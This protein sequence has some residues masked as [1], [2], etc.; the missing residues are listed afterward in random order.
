MPDEL[1]E[2]EALMTAWL[3]LL[4]AIGAVAGI[5]LV[6]GLL[7]AAVA[8]L[9]GFWMLGAAVPAGVSVVTLAATAAPF[10]GVPWSL[11]PVA[12]MSIAVLAVVLVLRRWLW[13]DVVLPQPRALGRAATITLI[14]APIA[15]AV[16][17]AAVI[18][19]PD[20]ISQTFDNI[21]HLNGIRF[22]LDTANASPFHLG[23]MT[24]SHTGGVPFYPS[25]WHAIG[26]LI[27]QVS[28]VSIPVASNA[29][30]FFF[31]ALW[32][33]SAL[34]LAS[35]L[36]RV[37][38]PMIVAAAATAIAVPSFPLL[39]VD[40]GVLYPY[41]LSFSM[42]GTA[43][44][45]AYLAIMGT[46]RERWAFAVISLGTL[47]GI[48]ISHPGGFMAFLLLATV[49]GAIRYVTFLRAPGPRGL[50]RWSL[51]GAAVYVVV[52]V[53]IWS[54]ARPPAEARN[55]TVEQSLGQAIGE[56]ATTSLLHGALNIA[57]MVLVTVGVVIAARRRST[58]DIVALTLLL[59]TGALFIIVSAL[60][61]WVLRDMATGP[62]YN[63]APRLAALLP[64]AWVP[65]VGIGGSAIWAWLTRRASIVGSPRLA[66]ALVAAVVALGLVVLPQLAV[67]R[68]AVA[69]AHESYAL[70][71][72]SLL[73][74]T[75]EKALLERLADHV[76]ADAV[77][78]GSAWTGTALA[79]AFS[80]RQV[81]LP[82]TLTDITPEMQTILD[83][84]DSAAADEPACRAADDLGVSFVLDFGHL[85]VHEGEHI[86]AGLDRLA[87]SD[88][89][90]LIDSEGEA[91]LYA[92]TGCGV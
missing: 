21:F 29:L 20:A 10:V 17:L 59:V 46:G 58:A 85:E 13:R 41:M 66:R 61:F 30:M 28:G 6:P 1:T 51:V 26:A 48:A 39:L 38:T 14:A 22:A 87:K 60:P 9:R 81:L 34:L 75:D 57:V 24:S 91:R 74:S 18:G 56:V 42:L 35:A 83:G 67:M 4:L 7:V 88:N 2:K 36:F 79:Y 49:I 32:P 80:G 45:F 86:Y 19:T 11:L 55:W 82:H 16:Q 43:L 63:N 73:L 71:D 3:E 54:R 25:A 64:F 33:V 76:P 52:F 70:S 78:V 84:L 8:G 69:E 12:V 65:L 89:V 50:R 15:I 27:V 5:I 31:A 37:S 23:S 53:V 40:Y 44:A 90:E 47:P 92:I 77:I 62:W 68:P 72:E